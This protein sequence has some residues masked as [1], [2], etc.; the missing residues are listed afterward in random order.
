L[1][2]GRKISI[3]IYVVILFDLLQLAAF[4]IGW[5]DKYTGVYVRLLRQLHW[6]AAAAKTKISVLLLNS[7]QMK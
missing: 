5:E 3:D 1:L 6:Q 4:F 7:H 2:W